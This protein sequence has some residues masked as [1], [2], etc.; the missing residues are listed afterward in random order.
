[1]I[2]Q[3]KPRMSIRIVPS[4][5]LKLGG[6]MLAIGKIPQIATAFFPIKRSVTAHIDAHLQTREA[7]PDYQA[8]RSLGC[9]QVY[10]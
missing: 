6:I 9:D 5:T 10:P 2:K 3:E 8:A 4:N 1:M 7:A